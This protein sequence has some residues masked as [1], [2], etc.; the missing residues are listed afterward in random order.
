[1]DE[2]INE[3]KYNDNISFDNLSIENKVDYSLNDLIINDI[4]LFKSDIIE[5]NFKEDMYA[6][7][8]PSGTEPKFKVYIGAN[9]L[10]LDA[11]NYK[12]KI[13]KDAVLKIFNLK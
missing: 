10:N 3:L 13:I 9:G 2:L 6:I 1:M 11:V 5:F 8:R 4:N 7:F 12:I